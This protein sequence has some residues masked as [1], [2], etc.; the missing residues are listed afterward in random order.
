MTQLSPHFALEEMTFSEKAMENDIDNKPPT[1]IIDNLLILAAHMETIRKILGGRPIKITSGYRCEELN[2]LVGGS[3]TSAHRF[4]LAVDF[5]CPGFG[6]PK[7]ICKAIEQA[8][9]H[10]YLPFD[11]L[12]YEGSWVHVG[13]VGGAK[14]PRGESFTKVVKNGKT[15]YLPGVLN[16]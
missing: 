4:G 11:Q 12:I 15:V 7:Q 3:E 2:R 13:F 9:Q 14:E 10:T 8:A 16:I 1:K 6:T 5:V